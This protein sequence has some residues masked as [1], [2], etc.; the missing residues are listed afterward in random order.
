MREKKTSEEG[1]LIS[2]GKAL[3]DGYIMEGKEKLDKSIFLELP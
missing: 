3:K 1:M 2:T